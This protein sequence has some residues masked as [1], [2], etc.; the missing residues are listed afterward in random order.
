MRSCTQMS[1]WDDQKG[2]DHK[3]E[4]PPNSRL[5]IV[6]G[7]DLGEEDFQSAFSKFGTIEEI[8]IVKDKQTGEKKGVTYVKFSKTSEAALA[9]EEMNGKCISRSPRPLKVLI[10][11]K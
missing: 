4:E 8:W 9:M 6:C 7:K 2:R 11:H 1:R 5:F 10:A 3:R